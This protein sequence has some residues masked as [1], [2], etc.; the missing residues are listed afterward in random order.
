M[1]G[2]LEQKQ[3]RSIELRIEMSR[4]EDFNRDKLRYIMSLAVELS[5]MLE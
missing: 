4:K 5:Q 1:L 2:Y 3:Q